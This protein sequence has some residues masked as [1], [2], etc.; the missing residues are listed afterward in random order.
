MDLS[1]ETQQVVEQGSNVLSFTLLVGFA[2]LS[3]WM[4]YLRT[5][6]AMLKREIME[7]RGYP[8]YKYLPVKPSSNGKHK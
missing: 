8:P 1:Q 7:L 5:E 3:G 2:G 6:I 4:L